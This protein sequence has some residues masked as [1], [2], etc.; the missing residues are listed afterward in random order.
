VEPRPPSTAPK[1]SAAVGAM[2]RGTYYTEHSAPQAAYGAL[3]IEWLEEAARAVDAPADGAPLVL[4][5][6]GAAGGGDSLQPMRRAIAAHREQHPGEAALVVHTDIP[7]NDFT[8]LFTL[9]E[10]SSDSYLR[11][12]G[13]F[14]MAAGR[15]FYERLFPDRYLSLGWCSIAVHWLSR[16][17]E[18]IPDHI[19]SSS[20]TGAVRDALREQSARDWE[21]FLAHRGAE[22]RPTGGLI[23]IGGAALE[24][25]SSGAEGLMAM[26][27]GVLR[28][29]VDAG[30]LR[31]DERRRMTIPT[32]NRTTEEFLAPFGSGAAAGLVLRRHAFRTLED[33]YLAAFHDDGDLVRYSTAVAAFFHAAFEPSLWAAL[34]PDRDRD[35]V[36]RRFDRELRAAIAADPERA[37]CGWHV[38]VMDIARS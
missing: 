32:W 34:D 35:A 7:T 33:P 29:L 12:P 11:D 31:D 19:Y 38:L 30:E 16:V 9:V 21:A 22:L 28:E 8:A 18:P 10:S 4:A 5:D 3:G 24:D 6:L 27:D 17:P 37:A 13:T 25:G 14:A 26:A 20:A 2:E 36:A 1:A 15:S 23:V